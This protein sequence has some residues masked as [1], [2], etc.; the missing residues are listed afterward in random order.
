MFKKGDTIEMEI[1]EINH[2]HISVVGDGNVKEGKLYMK[3]MPK[4]TVE[5][6]I[7]NED[8]DK[9]VLLTEEINGKDMTVLPGGT[10]NPDE[11]SG[12]TGCRIIKEYT[13]YEIDSG[14]LQLYD[15]RSNPDRD[16]RQWLISVIYIAKVDKINEPEMWA[17]IDEILQM[18][19]SFGYDHHR[20]I[21]NFKYN[22]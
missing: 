5:C 20:I 9:L 16:E 3:E 11:S 12:Q 10:A 19:D 6:L 2:N 8:E 13:G 18:E 15:F 7:V 22:C 21:Q 4:V 1:E 17:N 14:D